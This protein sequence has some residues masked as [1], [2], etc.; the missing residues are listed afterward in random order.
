MQSSHASWFTV[1]T[2]PRQ[3]QI[4]RENLERQGFHCFLPM[5]INPYQ[6]QSAGKPRIEPLFPRYLFLNA[7]ADQQ[8]LG[9]VRS[10]RGVCSLVRFGMQLATMPEFIIE[11]INH[12]CDPET[13]LVQLDPVPVEIGD[14]VKVFDGPFAGIEGI[15]RE[16]KGQNRALLLISML[17]TKSTVEVDA[18]LLKKAM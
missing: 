7:I 4:A 18:L 5:A 2:K 8:S 1:Y 12:R 17:G 16:R 14:K 15:F 6:R 9:P 13:G 11:T 3:E 10:T